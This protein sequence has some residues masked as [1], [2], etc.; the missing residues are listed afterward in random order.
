M[1]SN[2]VHWLIY[3]AAYPNLRLLSNR[4]LRRLSLNGRGWIVVYRL[5]DP[6]ILLQVIDID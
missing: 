3:V 5:D 4:K 6:V 2:D 1:P